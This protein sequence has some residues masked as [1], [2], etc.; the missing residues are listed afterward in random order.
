M[1]IKSI[2]IFYSV[3]LILCTSL[4]FAQTPPPP[5]PPPEL[6]LNVNCILLIFITMFYGIY[7]LN[8][9]ILSKKPLK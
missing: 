9:N 4:S 5:P 3:A 8:K 1:E 7:K 2:N 6:S